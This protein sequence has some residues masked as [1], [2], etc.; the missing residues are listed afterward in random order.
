MCFI[1]ST[2]G[3]TVCRMKITSLEKVNDAGMNYCTY[4]TENVHKYHL[5]IC[6]AA[7][8]SVPY[9]CWL[10]MNALWVGRAPLNNN[11]SQNLSALHS[12]LFLL[13]QYRIFCLCPETSNKHCY[14]CYALDLQQ[15]ANFL[16]LEEDYRSCNCLRLFLWL[17]KST[18][19]KFRYSVLRL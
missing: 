15:V 19:V 17:L 6:P 11:D 13:L 1:C 2:D 10:M 8:I 3:L 5:K 7:H 4:R 9:L 16:V 18:K 14:L 12:R